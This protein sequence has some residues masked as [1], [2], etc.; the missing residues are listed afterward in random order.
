M[1][2]IYKLPQDYSFL[3][4]STPAEE[5]S[6]IEK[7]SDRSTIEWSLSIPPDQ[8][9]DLQ[10]VAGVIP[11]QFFAAA[12]MQVAYALNLLITNEAIDMG[13]ISGLYLQRVTELECGP[14]LLFIIGVA[15]GEEKY[16][17]TPVDMIDRISPQ[18]S[19]MMI[20]SFDEVEKKEDL[21]H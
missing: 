10:K 17:I 20:G 2:Q 16:A 18:T 15:L 12:A 8:K 14:D 9:P 11:A 19:A 1:H 6:R 13:N 3:Y 21:L 5:L 4:W 7:I